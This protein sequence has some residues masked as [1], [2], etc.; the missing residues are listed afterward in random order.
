MRGAGDIFGWVGR[1]PRELVLDNATEA[2]RRVRGEVAESH[3][4]SLLRAHYRM[5]SRY[6]SPSSGNEKG[7]VEKPWGS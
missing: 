1:A 4:F 2:G 3:L 6:C 5:G 7:S